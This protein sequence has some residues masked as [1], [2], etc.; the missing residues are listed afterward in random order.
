MQAPP[1]LSNRALLRAHD[2]RVPF[3]SWNCVF[4]ETWLEASPHQTPLTTRSP[5]VPP[6]VLALRQHMPLLRAL[7]VLLRGTSFQVQFGIQCVHLEKISV[8]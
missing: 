7:Y 2:R 5:S 4:L 8:Q 6:H 1:A 3:F